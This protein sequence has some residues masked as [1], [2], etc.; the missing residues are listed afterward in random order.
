MVTILISTKD[1]PGELEQT[2]R[3]LRRQDYPRLELLVID[4]GSAESQEAIVRR[5]WPEARFIRHCEARGQ[6]LRRSEGF[7]IAQGQY[8]LQ[9]DD[10]SA[11]LE[12]D[13]LRRAVTYLET[14]QEVGVIAF[15]IFNGS[16]LPA[17][18]QPE[19]PRLVSS[20][21]GCGALLRTQAARAAGG[22]LAFFGSEWE[23][24]EFSLRLL[25]AGWAISFF[26]DLLIHHRLSPQNRRRART[27]MRGFRNKLW[28]MVIHY[29]ARRLFLEG[30]WVLAL[31]AWD[32]LRL[33]RPIWF[34]VG[35]GQMVAFL[36]QALR[37]RCPMS[38]PEMRR[39]DA[40]RFRHVRHWEECENPAP[41]TAS[42]LWRW[43]CTR[44]RNR[45]RQRSFWDR[46]PGDIGK[47]G[48]VSYEHEYVEREE[49]S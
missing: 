10:D 33:L 48:I 26:P 45:A 11:P 22:Y 38:D 35:I 17:V 44:W 46:R 47:S 30:T 19:Q 3:A 42:E 1:R 29:P 16:Q 9:L 25:R 21:V 40:L 6:S 14:H 18:L 32:A 24:D 41:V 39:Y 36:P 13:L 5:S 27:W 31:A 15:R 37:L 12:D 43:F 7:E 49:P 2:L 28:A 34:L 8:I 20:F 4:D 23:E